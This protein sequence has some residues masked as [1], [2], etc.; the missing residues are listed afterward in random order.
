MVQMKLV[1]TMAALVLCFGRQ[2]VSDDTKARAQVRIDTTMDVLNCVFGNSDRHD[3]AAERDVL[4]FIQASVIPREAA[5]W[6]YTLRQRVGGRVDVELVRVLGPKVIG[7]ERTTRASTCN[8][9]SSWVKVDRRSVNAEECAPIRSAVARLQG[10]QLPVIPDASITV[11]A[12]QYFIVAST[13]EGDE[14]SWR[15]AAGS[16]SNR[17]LSKTLPE[18]SDRLKASV[19]ACSK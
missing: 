8:D 18:W 6:Q 17:R 2:Q 16:R 4:W 13:T 7:D 19:E 3:P 15:I 11:D 1:A 9:L 14:Y 10:L 12:S 5:E